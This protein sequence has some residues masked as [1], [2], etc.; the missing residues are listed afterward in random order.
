MA[1]GK[2]AASTEARHA[3]EARDAEID[4]YQKSVSR[5]AAENKDLKERMVAKDRAHSAEVRRLKAE[6]NEGVSPMLAVVQRENA[7]LKQQVDL[8]ERAVKQARR[9]WLRVIERILAH[10]E[11]DHGMSRRAES[12]EA[13]TALVGDV[14]PSHIVGRIYDGDGIARHVGENPEAIAAIQ[15]ARGDRR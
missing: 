15:R 3:I 9:D 13:A 4:T 2:R 10:F 6:R 1:R 7:S 8:L 12:I 5:L 11:N 14:A